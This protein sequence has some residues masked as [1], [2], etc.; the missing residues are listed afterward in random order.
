MA[1]LVNIA[2]FA[3][4]LFVVLYGVSRFYLRGRDLSAHDAPIP[5]TFDSPAPSDA[6]NEVTDYLLE[7][8]TQPATLKATRKRF[9]EFGLSRDF[10]C[11][12]VS[13]TAELDGISVPGE[14]T[15][16]EGAD[17]SKR[18]LYIHG[19]A[20]LF[21]SS[22][23]H[24]PI[25][26]NIA[27][28]TGCVVFAPDYRLMPENRR[29]ASIDDCRI[30]YQWVLENSPEGPSKAG[31]ISVAGDSA[32]GNLTLCLVNW[33]R[34][35]G[36]PMPDAVVALSPATDSTVSGPSI[37]DNLATDH[38]LRPLASR[39]LKIPHW[40][41]MWV[42]W[43]T[44]RMIPSSKLI[45]PLHDNL[46]DLP[47]TL[48]H[49]STAEILYDDAK[50][51]TNKA[52]SQGSPV[53]LQSWPHLCHVWQMFDETLPEASHAFDEIAAFMHEQGVTK[54]ERPDPA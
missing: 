2:L 39:M 29:K 7:R 33:L 20:F 19:G 47:P 11:T 9:N 15:I 52:I 40:L 49:A 12:F 31:K 17:P 35:S 4:G 16:A 53:T 21:G 1:I 32:G 24:R 44:T 37:R 8:M 51:Y 45:S 30:A 43:A 41:L 14:W 3:A 10:A 5:V 27:K 23:S 34:D 28:R 48:I 50:R 26:A 46:G 13:Q 25:I 36:L 22:I 6:A 18:L 38:M 54:Q 42:T